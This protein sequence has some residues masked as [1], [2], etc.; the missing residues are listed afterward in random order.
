MTLSPDDSNLAFSYYQDGKE[1]IYT[2]NI[3]SG[4]V[5]KLT[6]PKKEDHRQP[7]FS[8]DGKKILFLKTDKENLQSL[9]IISSD[10]S[11]EKA[12]TRKDIHVS[13]AIFS[14]DGKQ[15]LFGALPAEELGKLE[16][17]GE[18]GYDLLSVSLDGKNIEKLTDEDLFSTHNFLLDSKKEVLLFK[19]DGWMEYSL[20][21][22]NVSPTGLLPGLTRDQYN[23][24]ISRDG[25]K[26]AYTEVTKESRN[27]SLFIYE[28]MLK[29]FKTG[30]KERLTNLKSSIVSPVFFSHENSIVFLHY[31]NS[32]GTP[33]KYRLMTVD[34]R[35]KKTEE[36]QLDLPKAKKSSLFMNSIA[37]VLNSTWTVA[38]LYS[39][40]VCLFTYLFRKGKVFLPG[41]ISIGLAVTLF[42]SS[43]FIAAMYD[44]WAGIAIGSIAA[45][46][47]ICSLFP[48]LFAIIAKR[49]K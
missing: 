49:L 26:I 36:I 35:T 1:A 37:S 48:L 28:L 31:S 7:V 11:S 21:S 23:V 45:G 22:A 19:D 29:D 43:F 46:L 41:L 14:P 4:K 25:Q 10:G 5:K 9:Y 47:F 33:E 24:A 44:P 42:A 17:E 18:E 16:G 39:L 27:R 40:I 32:A 15:A 12:L 3:K 38:G 20:G 30:K 8:P 6:H 34:L 13:E 2:A